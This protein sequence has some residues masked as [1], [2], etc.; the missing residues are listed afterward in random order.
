MRRFA[1]ERVGSIL[2]RLG[3][4]EG[5]EISHPWVTKSIER[6]QKKVE[7]YHFEIRRNLLEYDEVMNEQRTLVY[8]Q[9]QEVLEGRGL[10]GMIKNMMERLVSDRVSYYATLEEPGPD[11]EPRPPPLEELRQWVR[12]T[13][14]ID[15]PFEIEPDQPLADQE[16][17]L[18][19]RI[20]E[21]YDRACEEKR[22][23]LGPEVF[24]RVE[25]FILL[26]KIDEKWKDH[27]HA[28]DQLRSGISLRSYGQI[29][30]KVAYKQEGYQMFSQMIESLRS[31]VTQLV[32]Q[33][34]VER[35]DEAKLQSGLD[36][37]EYKHG[38][39][40]APAEGAG[41]TATAGSA[42]QGPRKPIINKQPKV[43]RNDPC[44]CGSG[45]KYK[46]CCG[47]GKV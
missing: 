36:K 5:E 30:P 9:R 28:M 2:K 43:G 25:R 26:L 20:L 45:K 22:A 39:A 37:A 14:R 21:A 33:V 41:Q 35:E 32:L 16:E 24:Q 12:S 23:A 1:S 34:R 13:Y 31:D 19:T 11:D 40:E 17:Q 18:S 10:A 4:K 44:P 8:A 15:P 3:M 7:A 47:A 6:A 27:L 46:R 42:P 38:P 29:D